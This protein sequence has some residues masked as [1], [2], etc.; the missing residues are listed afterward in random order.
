MNRLLATLILCILFPLSLAAQAGEGA[1]TVKT[2][3]RDAAI[4]LDGQLKAEGSPAVLRTSPGRH[5]LEAR[6][7]GFKTAREEVFVGDDAVVVKTLRLAVDVPVVVP[8][9]ETDKP[10]Y[11]LFPERDAFETEAEFT[12]RKAKLLKAYNARVAAG[13]AAS[14]PPAAAPWSKSATTSPAAASRWRSSSPTGPSGCCGSTIPTSN[15]PATPPGTSTPAVRRCPC[16][17]A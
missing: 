4:Y 6:K 12:A 13:D 7:D 9:A 5:T 16:T 14:L 3:P 8:V 2:E 11:Y 1:L 17:R 15:S 10:G